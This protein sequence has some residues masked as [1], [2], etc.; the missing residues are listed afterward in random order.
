[1]GQKKDYHPHQLLGTFAPMASKKKQPRRT[2]VS[3]RGK[4]VSIQFGES[5]KEQQEARD[6]M[7]MMAGRDVLPPVRT[8]GEKGDNPDKGTHGVLGVP[9]AFD[10]T[11]QRPD[12]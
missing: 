9:E 4:V 12:S 7:N 1:V 11:K 3:T 5:G 8:K 10:K 6:F 2:K